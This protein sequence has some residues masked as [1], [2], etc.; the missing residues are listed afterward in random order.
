MSLNATLNKIFG[1]KVKTLS[2]EHEPKDLNLC[3]FE[4]AEGIWDRGRLIVNGK[5]IPKNSK[6]YEEYFD[7]MNNEALKYVQERKS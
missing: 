2:V 1:F 3:S 5:V 4:L 7:F 6:A